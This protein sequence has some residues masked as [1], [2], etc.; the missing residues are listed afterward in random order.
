MLTKSCEN[1]GNQ[2]SKPRTCGLPEWSGRRFCSQECKS[3]S[4]KGKTTWNK[5]LRSES[6]AK[7]IPCRIC[8]EPTSSH[9]TEKNHLYGM[10]HCGQP[11]CA[12]ESRKIKN[13]N[14]SKKALEMYASGERIALR[15][16]WSNVQRVS[17]EEKLISPWLESLGWIPQYKFLTNVHTNK[18]PRMFRLD[19]ALP[20]H[21]LHIEIDGSVHRLRKGSDARRDQMMA[22]RGWSVLRID[23]NLVRTDIEA[24]KTL[25]TNWASSLPVNHATAVEKK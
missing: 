13:E 10:V 9:G 15:T 5:G 25:I 12:A 11:E 24:A 2:F 3:L 14:I 20:Y 4:Q 22:D 16:A 19:F 18:L 23:A 21:K 6:N 7:K 8:G 1:C 17:Q